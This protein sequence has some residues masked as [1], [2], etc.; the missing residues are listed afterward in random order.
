MTD[1]HLNPT[2]AQILDG[3][4][5]L[6]ARVADGYRAE[7]QA[8]AEDLARRSARATSDL[9]T[10]PPGARPATFAFPHAVASFHVKT[11][12]I[13]VELGNVAFALHRYSRNLSVA[14]TRNA[15]DDIRGHMA[16]LN[17]AYAQLERAY[18]AATV[19]ETASRVRAAAEER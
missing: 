14:Q 5:K 2:F 17:A 11:S 9:A 8:R 18:T 19:G 10:M 3:F 12:T 13:G 6:N 16:E 15:M 7:D 1:K 4:D